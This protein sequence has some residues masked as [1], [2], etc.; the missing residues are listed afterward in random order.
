[1]SGKEIHDKKETEEENRKMRKS[2]K[3]KDVAEVIYGNRND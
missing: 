3:E 1:M 2:R